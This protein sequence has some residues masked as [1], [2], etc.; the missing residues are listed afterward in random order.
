[1]SQGGELRANAVL[2]RGLH[3]TKRSV[4]AGWAR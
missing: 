1:M 4:A 3:T 2:I